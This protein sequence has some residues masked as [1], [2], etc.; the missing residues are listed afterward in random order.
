MAN[1]QML[2]QWQGGDRQTFRVWLRTGLVFPNNEDGGVKFNPNHDELG[3]FSSGPAGSDATPATY[4]AP[5]RGLPNLK[6][7]LSYTAVSTLVAENNKSGL[8]DNVVKALIYKESQFDPV[9]QNAGK[10][11]HATGLMQINQTALNEIKRKL[12][13]NYPLATM[14]DPKTN[15][16]AGTQYLSILS[17]R[18]H[19][20]AATL[21]AYKG[22]G[23]TTYHVD[24]LNAAKILANG[25]AEDQMDLLRKTFHR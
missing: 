13:V 24:I 4:P 15:I 5:V 19:G 1:T 20:V 12:Q 11:Q 7:A 16:V 6:R 9:V 10:G 17:S 3:R 2:P 22:D 21:D 18:N 14:T 8:P 25:R 23:R